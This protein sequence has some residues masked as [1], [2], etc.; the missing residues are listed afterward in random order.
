MFPLVQL[1]LTLYPSHKLFMTI[2][3]IVFILARQERKKPKKLLCFDAAII[4]TFPIYSSPPKIYLFFFST[5]STFFSL[6]FPITIIKIQCI[7]M[8]DHHS[9][10]LLMYYACVP[11]RRDVYIRIIMYCYISIMMCIFRALPASQSVL[12]FRFLVYEIT[13]VCHS[14]VHR[15]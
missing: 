13:N 8:P 6:F 10:R 3:K 11:I 2:F 9:L 14:L 12:E 7:K 5:G 15:H 4:V 1:L